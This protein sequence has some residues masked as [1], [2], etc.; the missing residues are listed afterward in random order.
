MSLVYNI[1]LTLIKN[2]G[3]RQAKKLL[4][5][6]G[7]AEAVFAAKKAKLLEIEGI[8]EKIASSIL[9]TDAL[10]KAEKQVAFIK[11]HK[12]EVL[13]YTDNNYPKRLRECYDA[14]ILLYFR[15]EANFNQERVIGIVGTRN[16]T[17]YGKQLCKS[18]VEL[19]KPYG[20]LIISGLAY[21]IDITA[22]KESLNLNIPT[23]GVLGHG[24]DRIYPAAHSE[25]ARNMTKGGGLLTEFLPETNPDKENFPKRNRI[26]AGLCDVLVVVEA[27]RKGGA[28]ITADIANSY[29]KDVYAFPG[30][31]NDLYSEGCNFLIKTN[32][33]GLIN[34]PKDLVFYMGWEEEGRS[35]VNTQATLPLNLSPVEQQIVDALKINALGID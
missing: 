11:K 4:N 26:I 25:I 17:T 21:G 30:R 3:S 9:N 28:L 13:F 7:S 16:A 34:D 32:R 10:V 23:V 8:G 14:P 35:S 22:H 27:S 6:F 1:A 31:T 20:V 19:L 24:L 18:L 2:V 33:A 5:T 15:G 29:F 12:I